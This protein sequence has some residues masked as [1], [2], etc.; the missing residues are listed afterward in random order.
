MAYSQFHDGF[1]T[2]PEIRSLSADEKLLLV[3]F[4]TNPYRHYSGI[5]FFEFDLIAPQTGL[6]DIKVRKGIDTLSKI[7]FIR[8]NPKFS[9]VWVVKMARHEVIRSKNTGLFSDKQTKGI[10]N[11]FERLHKCPLIKEFL[12]HYPELEIPYQYPISQVEVKEEV[13]AEEEVKVKAIAA[14][15][16]TAPSAAF[17]YSCQFFDIDFD[18][19]MKLAKE[20]PALTDELL[21][22]E[23]SKMEDWIIDNKS[24]R[25][26]Q[27]NGHL[28]N[29]R[30]FIKNWLKRVRVDGQQLFGSG[31]GDRY[32]G[33]KK[34]AEKSPKEA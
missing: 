32:G 22:E 21:K 19:R 25:K 1:W 29:A 2:D 24:K 10:A 13:K 17:F 26:Y 11:H 5:Y 3:W 12:A 9:M 6:S 33:L 14:S 8:Y 16:P 30:L 34:W 7:G 28:A 20:F 15:E 31:P 4:I 23:F 27:S 18:Y